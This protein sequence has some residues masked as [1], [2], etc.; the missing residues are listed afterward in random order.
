MFTVVKTLYE[1]LDMKT[2]CKKILNTVSLL[3][4][5]DRCSLFLVIDDDA[6]ENKK[7]LISVVF[8][9]QS[10]NSIQ[11]SCLKNEHAEVIEEAQE[12]IRIPYG[13]FSIH[14]FIRFLNFD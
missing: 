11:Q 2:T 6:S 9:A 12:Q 10:A 3:L 7:F 14:Y 13:K 4:D 8:D 1:S 5:A